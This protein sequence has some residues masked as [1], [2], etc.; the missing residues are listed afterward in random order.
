M[1]DRRGVQASANQ[2]LFLG[3]TQR[4]E[5]HPRPLESRR[6]EPP[7]DALERNEA[8]LGQAD[9]LRKVLFYLSWAILAGVPFDLIIY[10][11]YGDPGNLYLS[12]ALVFAGAVTIFAQIALKRGHL[13]AG[14]GSASAMLLAMSLLAVVL[15]PVLFPVLAIG[16]VLAVAII[17]PFVRLRG[18]KAL[19]AS[20]WVVSAA[21]IWIGLA[22]TASAT[23]LVPAA[24][25]R[26][27]LGVSF[28]IVLGAVL[29]VLWIY[30]SRL[31]GALA[32]ASHTRSLLARSYAQLREMD[33][34]R[35][36]FMSNAAHELNTPLTPLRLQVS[37]L[38]QAL[39]SDIT[40]AR[41]H[42]LEILDRN[43]ERLA[44]LVGDMLDATRLESGRLRLHRT[45]EDLSS[46]V[47]AAAE[48]FRPAAERA[49]V[50][51]RVRIEPHLSAFVDRV[52]IE[53]VVYNLI[54]NA[55]KFTP[56]RGIID[57]EVDRVMGRAR[58]SVRDSGRGIRPED[59]D[60]LFRPFSQVQGATDAPRGGSG[61]GLYIAHG[62]LKQHGGSIWAESRGLGHGTRFAFEVALREA[63]E[64][65]MP[66]FAPHL[67]VPAD[68]AG[69][70][71]TA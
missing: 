13:R 42:S 8:I 6:L 56:E 68:Q 67:A 19:V 20:A 41:A 3:T 59:L 2:R 21:T 61:L 16:P 38:R 54:S 71:A 66:R 25:S 58:V 24:V 28:T 5:P 35:G 1:P 15:R 14:V 53:Q 36:Q 30:S 26:A 4:P 43:V 7:L 40:P 47:E 44:R 17:L 49:R 29:L 51:L 23:D 50:S 69:L 34:I 18:F 55:L 62:I 9:R 31:T 64:P 39:R 37:V 70:E 12:L 57:V 33:R 52:R 60:L 11:F 22:L 48:S 63:A 45:A 32:E 27:S 10:W 65:P 46:V